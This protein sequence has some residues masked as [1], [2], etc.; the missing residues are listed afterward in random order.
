[1]TKIACWNV[2]TFGILGD[3]SAQLLAIIKTMKEKIIELLTHSESCWTGCGITNIRSITI[4]HSVSPSNHVHSIAIAQS[5]VFSLL[6]R[7][8]VVSS[9]PSLSTSSIFISRL[10]C[11]M[12]QL[13]PSMPPPTMP[14]QKLVCNR[15]LLWLQDTLSSVPPRDMVIIMGNF[16][17]CIGSNFV[18]HISVIGPH[19]LGEC[20][21]NG[22]RLL[23]F[24]MS[25]KLLIINTWFQHK[26][27][28]QATWYRHCDHS[29][30]CHMMDFVL[31]ISRFCSSVL[32]TQVFLS[33]YYVSEHE[34]VVPSWDF[35]LRPNAVR[36]EFLSV[37]LQTD[38][39]THRFS[40]GPLLAE[41]LHCACQAE[42][43]ELSWSDFKA[44]M[45]DTHRPCQSFQRNRRKTGWRMS[46]WICPRRR[47]MLGFSSVV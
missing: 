20:D 10:I 13:L 29:R 43:P 14:M 5:H 25:N 12:P 18:S 45:S 21:E 23:D 46:C 28:Y 39:L 7:L 30:P 47:K 1:M 31:I 17:A 44:A 33:T 40:L 8:L 3:Q 35:R 16:N 4:V 15:Q 42:S 19:G 38:I 37:R 36:V 34:M 26:P 11:H 9:I 2:R 41:V 27:L 24:C 22:M 32:D 6:G